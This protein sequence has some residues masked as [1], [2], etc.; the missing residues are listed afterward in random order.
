MTQKALEFGW[1]QLFGWLVS[2]LLV[3]LVA[4]WFVAGVW[5]VVG[6]LLFGW[7]LIGCLF[8][9]CLAGWSHVSLVACLVGGWLVSWLVD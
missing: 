8:G 9:W 6:G 7:W 3:C 4:V 1:T 5:L 2:W